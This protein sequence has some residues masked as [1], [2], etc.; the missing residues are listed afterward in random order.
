MYLRR[1]V[2]S[3]A[4]NYGYDFDEVYER[5]FSDGYELAEYLFSDDNSTAAMVGA[6]AALPALAA[7]G[8]Y[9]ASKVGGKDVARTKEQYE[10]ALRNMTPAQ[11]A[12]YLKDFKEEVK[13]NK[14]LKKLALSD[15]EIIKR[16]I[17][18]E[19]RSVSA[20]RAKTL[21]SRKAADFNIAKHRAIDD[22]M[23][24]FNQMAKK[25]QNK[26]LKDGGFKNAAEYEKFL[27]KQHG[28]YKATESFGTIKGKKYDRAL[29]WAKKNKALAGAGLL[30]LGAAG[31]GAGYLASRD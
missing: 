29:N 30:G 28:S 20:A 7:A 3:V 14:D 1:K 16:A 25:D 6:G 22:K 2:F 10:A 26:F 4:D 12:K 11:R 15:D 21:A 27:D 31:A 18:G 8:V 17:T 24:E 13:N 5:A 9:G 19:S 23:Y